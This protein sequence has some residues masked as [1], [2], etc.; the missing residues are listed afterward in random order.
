MAVV[1]LVDSGCVQLSSDGSHGEANSKL[2]VERSTLL[3]VQQRASLSKEVLVA[4]RVDR[5]TPSASIALKLASVVGSRFDANLLSMLISRQLKTDD[6]DSDQLQM[7]TSVRNVLDILESLRERGMV[8]LSTDLVDASGRIPNSKVDTSQEDGAG[9]VGDAAFLM[10]DFVNGVTRSVVYSLLPMRQR[11]VV[12]LNV[13]QYRMTQAMAAPI[14]EAGVLYEQAARHFEKACK[15]VEDLEAMT[16]MNALWCWE[17]AAMLYLKLHSLFAEALTAYGA[18]I[19]I[20]HLAEPAVVPSRKAM[21]FR[22]SSQA[23]FALGDMTVGKSKLQWSLNLLAEDA[24]AAAAAAGSPPRFAEMLPDQVPE[25][26]TTLQPNALE[27]LRQRLK[28]ML[29]TGDATAKDSDAVSCFGCCFGGGRKKIDKATE[30]ER[31]ETLG[32]LFAES[33]DL[34]HA[35]PLM[36]ETEGFELDR[37]EEC[38]RA[39]HATALIGVVQGSDTEGA[40]EAVV[41]QVQ[42]LLRAGGTAKALERARA[43]AAAAPMLPAG[44]LREKCTDTANA[45]LAVHATLAAPTTDAAADSVINHPSWKNRM[46]SMASVGVA[47]AE[48]DWAEVALLLAFGALVDGRWNRAQSHAHIAA[49]MFESATASPDERM[50]DLCRVAGAIGAFYRGD[51][52]SCG[53]VADALLESRFAHAELGRWAAAL[54]IATRSAGNDYE[55]AVKNLRSM[56]RLLDDNPL[57]AGVK[58]GGAGTARPQEC[59]SVAAVAR[60]FAI[61]ALWGAG[62]REEALEALQPVVKELAAAPELNPLLCG[63]AS[64]A[65]EVALRARQEG[66]LAPKE[67]NKHV[68]TVAGKLAELSVRQPFAAMCAEWVEIVRAEQDHVQPATRSEL[69]RNQSWRQQSR[70]TE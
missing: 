43:L 35:I 23:H 34:R 30:Q 42:L 28:Y 59:A 54:G 46:T 18:A 41:L 9:A 58:S 36:E 5:L 10:W 4:A 67:A 64:V 38:L 24:E 2:V 8:E 49:V 14:S 62:E 52:G 26:L 21:W 48:E 45:L 69:G 65:A 44:E 16:V 55:N 15:G 29:S 51:R 60:A 61:E 40:L 19:N 31:A 50:L 63:A 6:E 13:A 3:A 53:P 12:H 37:R 57:M 70:N 47:T 33:D 22:F 66:F 56:E 25:L 17:V 68:D 20:A 1:E 11:R 39:L 32:V 7:E 27:L